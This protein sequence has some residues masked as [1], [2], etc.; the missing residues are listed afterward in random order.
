MAYCADYTSLLCIETVGE[1]KIQGQSTAID[2]MR[3][4]SASMVCSWCHK[5]R[6]IPNAFEKPM[7]HARKPRLARPVGR[8][9][10]YWTEPYFH[11]EDILG[12]A[13]ALSDVKNG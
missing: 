7:V 11:K 4:K 2:I 8:H 13:R 12:C 6:R 1:K 5:H 9:V 3:F 10:L